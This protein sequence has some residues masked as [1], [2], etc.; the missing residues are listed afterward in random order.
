MDTLFKSSSG[1]SSLSLKDLTEARD[2]F[3]YHLINKKNVVATALG[4]YRIRKDDPWPTKS[5]PR[6]TGHRNHKSERRTLFNSEV[7]PYSWPCVYVFVS[8][9][10][11]ETELAHGDAS[12]VV[13]K[14][15]Y[16]P[17]GR[18]VTLGRAEFDALFG[19]RR[20]RAWV[21]IRKQAP[22]PARR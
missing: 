3:H 4:L 15:L 20:K 12:D 1:F 21:M 19:E 14:A 6:A 18:S 9:W 8:S 13:P 22:M 7:R 11:Y 2:L 5:H 16:L 10:E 17:D